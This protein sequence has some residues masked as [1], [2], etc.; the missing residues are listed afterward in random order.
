MSVQQRVKHL[1]YERW[2]MR[3]KDSWSP[4]IY[5][6]QELLS[7]PTTVRLDESV[8]VA[9]VAGGDQCSHRSHDRRDNSRKSGG[10][11]DIVANLLERMKL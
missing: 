4:N 9:V 2:Y 11:S 5:E 3:A 8:V 6:A 7:G 10:G 1:Y